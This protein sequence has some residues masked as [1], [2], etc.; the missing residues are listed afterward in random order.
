MEKQYIK[1]DL[2]ADWESLQRIFIRPEDD[3]SRETLIKYM[4]Q[5]LFGLHDFLNKNVGVTEAISLKALTDLY[6]ETVISP[7][8]E[9]KLADVISDIIQGIA[10]RAVNVAS[11]YFVGHMT[12]AIPFFMVHLKAIVAALNQNV[13]KLETSKVLSVLEKQVLAKIHRL[14][15]KNSEIFYHTHVQSTDTTLGSFTTGGTTANLT[16]LWVARNLLLKPFDR[17]QGVEAQGMAEALKAYSLDKAVILA[18]PRGHFSLKKAGGI[19]GIG[20]K[21]VIPVD[22]DAHHRVDVLKLNRRIV[23]LKK[24]GKIGIMAVVGIAGATETGIVDPLDAIADVCEDHGLHF[25]VDAAWGGPVMLSERYAFKLKGIERGDSVTI[26][27]HKQF[28]M[29]MTC[30]MVYFR[31]PLAMDAIAYH[32]NYVNREGSVDLGIKTL[33]GSREANS[34]IL[35]SSL[36]IMGTRGY[37]LMVDHGIETAQGFSRAIHARELFEM[38]TEPELNILTYRI[39]PPKIKE[40]ILSASP[41]EKEK[42]EDRVNQL[43]IKVQR[44]QREAG[45][46]FVSRTRIRQGTKD[47][48]GQVVLRAVIMNPMTDMDILNEV[49]DEQEEIAKKILQSPEPF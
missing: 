20:H 19:L 47:T 11:P 36:K 12:A 45:K 18:S 43:N 25:H 42:L 41:G 14:I 10:P 2:V 29:P 27:G 13:I 15:Y 38:V 23:D 7:H 26:D 16:A 48:E 33:E 1:K 22:V 6:K 28:F 21:N 5:I 40:Q 30:G 32:A 24:N 34:L 31:D 44:E 17:F 46:S 37:G 9:K 39:L 49:L 4:E 3:A 8:P 35:D